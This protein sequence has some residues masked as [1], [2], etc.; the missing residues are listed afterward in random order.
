MSDNHAQPSE[1]QIKPMLEAN[2]M[3]W[4]WFTGIILKTCIAI[5]VVL[6]LMAL[7][8]TGHKPA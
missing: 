4:K 2:R 6:A 1:Q 8:L 5:A 7:F 3:T